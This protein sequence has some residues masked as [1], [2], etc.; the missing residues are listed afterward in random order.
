MALVEISDAVALVGMPGPNGCIGAGLLANSSYNGE[1]GN[2]TNFPVL[3]QSRTWPNLV[4]DMRRPA[5][6]S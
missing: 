5:T 6:F 4:I 1:A 3:W 2:E